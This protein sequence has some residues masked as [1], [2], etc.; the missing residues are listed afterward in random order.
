MFYLQ[1]EDAELANEAFLKAQTLDSD[2]ALAWVGQG[3]TATSNKHDREASALFEHATSLTAAVPE[4]D[5][6]YAT[7]L[8]RRVNASTNSRAISAEALLPAFFVL[9]RYCKQ[10]PR[11]ATALHLF[12][13]VCERVG[14]VELGIEAIGRA[15]VVLE[16]AYEE[17]EDSAIER[18]FTIAH[19]NVAR[20]KLA[21]QDYEGALESYQV[22]ISLLPEQ[23][24]MGDADD[25]DENGSRSDMQTLLAQCQFGSGLANF[26]LGQLPEALELF[27]AA[28]VTAADDATI[29]GHVVVLL[30]QALWAIGTDEA[31]ESAKNQL[32]Q[33]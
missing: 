6:E 14:H 18:Q 21:V 28:M 26:K 12:G 33:R 22:A 31:K 8:F 11:D 7:R 20:L 10:R 23:P 19:A 25:E 16:A 1:Y 5:L 15:I 30:V 29:R 17:T 27:E 3:L 9:D 2:Y 32:L 4:A 24:E 13:L